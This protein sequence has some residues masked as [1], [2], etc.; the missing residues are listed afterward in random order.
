MVEE[1]KVD[2]ML[3]NG[4]CVP[5]VSFNDAG[6]V[7]HAQLCIICSKCV[8][9]LPLFGSSDILFR[10]YFVDSIIISAK[11]IKFDCWEWTYNL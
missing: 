2:D 6:I 11:H 8:A 3:G 4:S 9:S 7:C 10:H 1:C 5:H